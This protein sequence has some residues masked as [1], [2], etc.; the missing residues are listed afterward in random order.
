MAIKPKR[1][2]ADN[3][4]IP[5]A[6]VNKRGRI[7]TANV[8]LILD[9]V[10]K[11]AQI[12]GYSATT[13]TSTM[14]KSADAA[15]PAAKRDTRPDAGRVLD[16]PDQRR[17]EESTEAFGMLDGKRVHVGMR[18]VCETCRSSL[19]YCFCPSPVVRVSHTATSV[20]EFKARTT[21]FK[22]DW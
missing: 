4:I 16:V 6:D 22:K 2:L 12:E 9:A 11:G 19:T 3:G 17:F 10:S 13:S 20:V 1:W 8:A 21:P 5:A 7:S 14:V 15:A 18:Q